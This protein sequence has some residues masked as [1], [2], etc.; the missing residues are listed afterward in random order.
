MTSTVWQ[1]RLLDGR[2]EAESFGTVHLWGDTYEQQQAAE[3][4]A[5]DRMCVELWRVEPDWERLS[6]W[7]VRVW[8]GQTE[9]MAAAEE[10]LSVLRVGPLARVRD[11]EELLTRPRHAPARNR[12]RHV[13]R[14]CDAVTYPLPG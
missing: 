5:A 1:W 10:W 8:C 6:G 9:V 7:R 2:G 12:L 4:W 3:R 14:T 11:R 13:G